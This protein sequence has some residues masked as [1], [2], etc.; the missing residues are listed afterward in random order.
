MATHLKDMFGRPFNVGDLVM[1]R[2][3]DDPIYVR[4]TEIKRDKNDQVFAKTIGVDSDKPTQFNIE[5]R[6]AKY[7]L[8]IDAEPIVNSDIALCG[9]FDPSKYSI[10]IIVDIDTFTPIVG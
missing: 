4:V 5:L 1:Y 3:N 7:Y 2:R 8:I 9:K 6:T 10:K